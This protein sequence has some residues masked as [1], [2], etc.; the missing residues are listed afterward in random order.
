MSLEKSMASDLL[1]ISRLPQPAY[2]SSGG[3]LIGGHNTLFSSV[4]PIHDSWILRKKGLRAVRLRQ[5]FPN[6]HMGIVSRRMKMWTPP[7][8][9]KTSRGP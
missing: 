6:I 2:P 5:R 9:E 1:G 3:R 4:A 8:I 7:M